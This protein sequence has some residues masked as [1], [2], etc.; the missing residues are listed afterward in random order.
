M[1]LVVSVALGS[2]MDYELIKFL[3]S[4][5]LL[6]VGCILTCGLYWLADYGL[7]L[8][9]KVVA[10]TMVFTAFLAWAM[11]NY[12]EYQDYE[13]E[14]TMLEFSQ[15]VPEGKYLEGMEYEK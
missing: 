8:I 12:E 1:V 6:G 10:S 5:C 7:P 13:A 14:Q 2:D 15:G 4:I 9:I 11:H 3:L